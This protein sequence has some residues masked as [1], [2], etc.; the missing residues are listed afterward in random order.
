MF[1][2]IVALGATVPVSMVALL[3]GAPAAAVGVANQLWTVGVLAGAFLLAV[4]TGDRRIV[5]SDRVVGWLSRRA[6][7]RERDGRS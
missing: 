5:S 2:V 6:E 4:R 3:A 7:R 1:W